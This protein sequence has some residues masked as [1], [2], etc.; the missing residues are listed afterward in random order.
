MTVMTREFDGFGHEAA[1]FSSDE[2]SLAIV[3]PFVRAGLAHGEPVLVVLDEHLRDL[4]RS[5]IGEMPGLHYH[6]RGADR[7]LPAVAIRVVRDQLTDLTAH[8][9][10]PARLVGDLVAHVRGG[11]WAGWARYEAAINRIY[12]GFPVRALCVY[13]TRHAPEE[14]LHDV[15]LTH[16]YLAL[17]GGARVPNEEYTDP[18]RFLAE[19]LFTDGDPNE[20]GEPVVDLIDPL[21]M[22]ARRAVRE[23]AKSC[24]S[25]HD[26]VD[27]AVIA[28]GE[29]VANALR[30]GGPRVRVRVW[31]QPERL[32]VLVTDSG[33]GP[34][35]PY[36]GLVPVA[37][38][39]EG[40]RGLWMIHQVCSD[41]SMHRCPEGFTLRM[42]IEGPPAAVPSTV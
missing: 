19:R 33:D 5:T 34:R 12:A 31:A 26:H 21:P 35:D 24:L 15:R 25:D 17:P 9:T 22:L 29:A 38:T 16:P 23:T 13:D 36:V 37:S 11:R 2:E 42:V 8:A 18:Q 27:D 39:A 28:A 6:D 32:V 4:V 20:R 3:L 7:T 41:V 30:H 14:V 1:F 10:R 40:G